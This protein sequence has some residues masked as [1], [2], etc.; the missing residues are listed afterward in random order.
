MRC[1]IPATPAADNPDI[2]GDEQI[3]GVT[4]PAEPNAAPETGLPYAGVAWTIGPPNQFDGQQPAVIEGCHVVDGVLQYGPCNDPFKAVFGEP[5]YDFTNARGQSSY[6]NTYNLSQWGDNL[7]SEDN[8]QIAT[9]PPVLLGE[10]AVLKVWAAG[11]SDS[12]IAPEFDPVEGEGYA[13]NSCG[14]AVLSADDNSLLASLLIAATALEAGAEPDSFELD[15][16]DL[17]GQKVIIEVVDAFEGGWGW[18]A[19]DEIRITH[20]SVANRIASEPNATPATFELMQNYPNPFNPIT[21]INYTLFRPGYVTLTVFDLHGNE[22]A[23]LVNEKKSGGTHTVYFDGTNLANG[24][25]F[26]RLKSGSDVMT[27]KMLL[28]K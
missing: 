17:A 11:G 12:R 16:S 22:V 21:V 26:Y 9:S 23:K 15:L 8:D 18:I 3:T 13:T 6:L 10:G 5:P 14:I 2:A 20:A 7:H 1:L 4:T 28:L 24:I 27:K 25:Y 19:V